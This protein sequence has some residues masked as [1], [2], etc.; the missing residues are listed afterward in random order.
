[1]SSTLLHASRSDTSD[2]QRYAAAAA[3]AAAACT[4]GALVEQQAESEQGHAQARVVSAL[5]HMQLKRNVV[6]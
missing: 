1:M 6:T 4:S 3:A 5:A 2:D